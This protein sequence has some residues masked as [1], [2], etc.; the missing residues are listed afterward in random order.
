MKGEVKL[1]TIPWEIVEPSLDRFNF[2]ALNT[3]LSLPSSQFLVACLYL[4]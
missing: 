2:G 1:T 3:R 4:S